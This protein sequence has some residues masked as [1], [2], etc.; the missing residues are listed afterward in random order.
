MK[1]V[2]QSTGGASGTQVPSRTN[3]KDRLT[4]VERGLLAATRALLNPSDMMARA[5]LLA[6][7]AVL[8]ETGDESPSEGGTDGE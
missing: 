2:R 4:W 5:K 3:L 6:V 1:T 8:E 7:A